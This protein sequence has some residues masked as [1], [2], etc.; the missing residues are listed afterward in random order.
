MAI[1]GITLVWQTTVCNI[2]LEIIGLTLAR[3]VGSIPTGHITFFIGGSP[4]KSRLI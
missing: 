2:H 4:P 1:C 3:L